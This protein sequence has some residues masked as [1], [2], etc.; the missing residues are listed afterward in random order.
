MSANSNKPLTIYD[1]RVRWVAAVN[2]AFVVAGIW[3]AVK[4]GA[5][6]SLYVP[7]I[8]LGLF[9]LFWIRDLLFGHRLKLSCDSSTLRWQDGKATDS[10]RLR[11]IRKVLIGAK[12]IRIGGNSVMGWT[13]VRFTLSSGTECELPPNIASG[14]RAR[15]WRRLRQL[16]THIRIVSEVTVEPISEPG[17][18]LEK[19]KDETD[20]TTE[21]VA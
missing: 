8:F 10:V 9:S 14:L 13:Y 5:G 12:T 15:S 4:F 21:R 20:V 18:I 7:V 16:V 19:W 11:D 2:M 6:A 3:L 1:H 17:V